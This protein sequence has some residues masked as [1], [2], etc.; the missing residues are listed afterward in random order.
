MHVWLLVCQV[1]IA[2]KVNMLPA[3]E[4]KQ[5]FNDISFIKK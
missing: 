3:R 4:T 1:E 5:E 2:S